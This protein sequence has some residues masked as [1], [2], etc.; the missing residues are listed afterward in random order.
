MIQHRRK[1]VS[2]PFG[3]QYTFQLRF[4][5]VSLVN[6]PPPPPKNGIQQFHY[7]FQSCHRYAVTP[8]FCA[9]G[10]TPSSFDTAP[11]AP[12]LEGEI[13]FCAGRA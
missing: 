9:N 4:V 1:K 10:K 7:T 2:P 12:P 5:P 8:N 3:G 6:P 11:H 13:T